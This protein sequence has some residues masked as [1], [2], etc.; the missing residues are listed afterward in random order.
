MRIIIRTVGKN[1][2]SPLGRGDFQPGQ[3][4]QA[5]QLAKG[6]KKML[7]SGEVRKNKKTSI[8]RHRTTRRL[9]FLSK[10]YDRV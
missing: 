5:D 7:T 9:Y 2:S 1:D 4:R 10:F 6:G 3:A 8:N